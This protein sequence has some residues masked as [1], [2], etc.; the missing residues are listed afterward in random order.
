[1]DDD[2]LKQCNQ[3]SNKLPICFCK[4]GRL[5]PRTTYQRD[6]WTPHLLVLQTRMGRFSRKI[7]DGSKP[8]Q[9]GPQR[10]QSRGCDTQEVRQDDFLLS[11]NLEPCELFPGYKPG[12]ES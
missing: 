3:I 8:R 1:M 6:W 12:C 7:P 4:Y 9:W 11:S 2:N 10:A 5:I